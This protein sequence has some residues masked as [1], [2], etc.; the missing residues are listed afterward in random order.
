[1]VAKADERLS[2]GERGADLR[3]GHDHVVLA[4]LMILD[5]DGFGYYPPS[6]DDLIGW[7]HTFRSSM[8][9]NIQMVFYLPR[10]GKGGE[11]LV[12]V[13]LNGEEAR[14][15]DLQPVEGPYYGWQD[16]RSYLHSR[17]A[18]FVNY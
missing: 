16:L 1:M 5:L 8:A 11:P 10:N 13:L 3:F 4:L 6:P 7:F 2:K 9:A 17:T 15:G 12:K 14:L 18:L